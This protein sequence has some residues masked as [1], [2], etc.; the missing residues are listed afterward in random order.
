MLITFGVNNFYLLITA[1]N[2][3]L[4]PWGRN[5][6]CVPFSIYI[7]HKFEKHKKI[8][9]ANSSIRKQ[10]LTP[11]KKPYMDRLCV[12]KNQCEKTKNQIASQNDVSKAQK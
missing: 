2:K 4:K 7:V 12:H 10:G 5:F 1:V 8:I 9:F 6:L 11:A 3:Y